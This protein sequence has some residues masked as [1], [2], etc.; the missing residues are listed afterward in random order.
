M[1]DSLYHTE[2]ELVSSLKRGEEEAYSYL[3]DH[4]SA[5]L[6][7]VILKTIRKENVAQ[8][9]L[10]EVFVKIFQNINHY[11]ESKGK[12]FT[13]MLRISRNAAI[14]MVRSKEYKKASKIHPLENNVNQSRTAYTEFP[15]IDHIGLEKVLDSLDESHRKI[16]DLAYFKGYSQKEIAEE[17]SLPL[18]TV[19][20]KVRSALIQLRK[21]LNIS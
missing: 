3:Y 9:L 17:L 5:A 21:V 20:T 12:L 19:K 4:Y 6:Y 13:W 15:C 1:N 16:I 8:D 10:Q 7:G 2:K 14:D 18:G 11:D